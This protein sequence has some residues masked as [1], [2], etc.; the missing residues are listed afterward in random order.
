[1][2]TRGAVAVW[3]REVADSP[4]KDND[5]DSGLDETESRMTAFLLLLTNNNR[6]VMVLV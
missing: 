5:G 2:T 3:G 6:L 4:D 1:M